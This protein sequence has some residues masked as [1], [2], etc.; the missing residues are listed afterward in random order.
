MT[1]I[2]FSH[3]QDDIGRVIVPMGTTVMITLTVHSNVIPIVSW[4]FMKVAD[5]TSGP[6]N[7]SNLTL[8]QTMDP[9]VLEEELYQVREIFIP[10][11]KCN[12]MTLMVKGLF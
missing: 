10:D 12:C 7:I 11:M 8:P 4:T 5:G 1:S 3:E 6:L 9:T 2:T